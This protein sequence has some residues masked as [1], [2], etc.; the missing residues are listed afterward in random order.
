MDFSKIK[1]L[2]LEQK[3][4]VCNHFSKHISS[5]Y[6]EFYEKK[7]VKIKTLR[8]NQFEEL[9]IKIQDKPL[10]GSPQFPITYEPTKLPLLNFKAETFQPTPKGLMTPN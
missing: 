6:P 8:Q 9:H 2:S 1:T 7:L 10:A 3:V 5:L 4:I